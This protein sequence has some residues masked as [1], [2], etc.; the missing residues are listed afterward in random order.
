M[1]LYSNSRTLF[2]SVNALMRGWTNY[3]RYTHNAPQLQIFNWWC[4]G[5]DTFSDE[6][7]VAQLSERCELLQVDPTSGKQA[8]HQW[9][10]YSS[11]IS[12]RS[13]VL[14]S[15][16]WSKPKMWNRYQSWPGQKDAVMNNG[17]RLPT[18]QSNALN[19]VVLLRNIV[20]HQTVSVNDQNA[21]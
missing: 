17:W 7:I 12:H 21:S 20:H 13:D 2:T 8:L 4:T 19:I 18:V 3:F 9:Q 6:N 10:G 15:A 16:R 11:G 1:P 5:L 14:S